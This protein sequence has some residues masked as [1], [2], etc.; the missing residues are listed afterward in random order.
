M[1]KLTVTIAALVVMF[2]LTGTSAMACGEPKSS[3]STAT[4][5]T[6]TTTMSGTLVCLGCNLKKSEEA[7]AECSVYG[8]KHALKTSDGRYI[9]LLENKYSTDL[10]AGE[11]YRNKPMELTGTLFANSNMMDVQSFTVDGKTKGWCGGCKTMDA[12]AAKQPS[13]M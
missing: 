7:R 10:V 12:C 6:E 4:E 9:S 5:K 3:A 1:R 11:N 13:E 2:A 8:H